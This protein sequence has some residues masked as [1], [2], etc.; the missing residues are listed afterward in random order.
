MLLENLHTD[1]LRFRGLTRSDLPKLL[2]FFSDPIATQYLSIETDKENFTEK[3]MQGQCR[4]YKKG[5]GGL[6]AIELKSTG[7]LIGQCGLVWQFV[8]GIPKWEVGYHFFRQ[9]WGNGYATEA[10]QAC[11]NFC[12]ENEMAETLISLIH[13]KNEKSKAVAKRTGLAFWKETD[14]QGKP[15]EVYKIIRPDW[16][17]L[18]LK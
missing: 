16:E 6:H 1:R 4:R 13:P 3:W 18:Y 5:T 10:A 7:E 9:F 15:V 14:F 2:H 11:R 17:T 8:D 12:F